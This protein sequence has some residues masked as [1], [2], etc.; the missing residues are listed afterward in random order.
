MDLDHE[1]CYC[2]HVSKRKVVNFVKQRRPR[3]APQI[4]EWFGAGS[5]CGWCIPF[6]LKIHAQVLRG[7]AVAGDD[8]TP[9]EYESLRAK[10]R[11]LVAEGKAAKNTYE[12]PPAPVPETGKA[13]EGS[14]ST[15]QNSGDFD[16]TRYFSR[17]RPDPEPD[18]LK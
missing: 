8:I 17:A 16:F 10:Y 11:Q 5:G 9:E 3:G 15:E 6:L 12:A 18:N 14:G 4:S 13:L 1:L 2:F 7:E